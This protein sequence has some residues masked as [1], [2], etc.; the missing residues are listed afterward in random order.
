MFIHK[1]SLKKGGEKGAKPQKQAE[2]K[3][4]RKDYHICVSNPLF[5]IEVTRSR[6]NALLGN[7]PPKSGSTQERNGRSH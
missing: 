7:H 5:L 1:I 4:L 3:T 6:Y 2:K